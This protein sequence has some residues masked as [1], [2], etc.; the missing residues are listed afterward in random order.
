MR[1]PHPAQVALAVI[2]VVSL[3][4]LWDTVTRSI[5]NNGFSWS[6]EPSDEVIFA[7]ALNTLSWVILMPALATAAAASVLG[8]VL[9]WCLSPDRQSLSRSTRTM[10]A[11]G[12]T[13]NR[14]AVTTPNA[15]PSISNS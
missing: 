8:L 7:M 4:A 5:Q 9:I 13:E 2:A 10:S 1:R 15:S 6:G 12:P 3:I 14:T 11:A